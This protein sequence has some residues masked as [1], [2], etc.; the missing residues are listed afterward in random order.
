VIDNLN[1]AIV[2]DEFG[3]V[4]HDSKTQTFNVQTF[5]VQ[6]PTSNCENAQAK[7]TLGRQQRLGL[8]YAGDAMPQLSCPLRI[9]ISTRRN[10]SADSFRLRQTRHSD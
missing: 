3:F 4:W 8:A 5:N 6:R 7:K 9:S 1:F 2:D 10:K